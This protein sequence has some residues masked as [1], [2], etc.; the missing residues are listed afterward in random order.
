MS[1]VKKEDA[2]IEKNNGEIVGPYSASFAGST[3][4]INDPKADVEEGDTVLRLLPNGK[5]ERSYVTSATFYGTGIGGRGPH[6]QIKFRKGAASVDHGPRQNF[7]INNAQSVQI[8]DFN[9]QNVVT[10]FEA[11]LAQ[12]ES[13]PASLEEKVEAKSKLKSFL[14]HPLVVSIMGSAAGAIIKNA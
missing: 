11:L 14:S 5:E 3:I 4:F 12:I 8:G 7:H 1:L 13:S 6:F 2:R 9:T 10:S